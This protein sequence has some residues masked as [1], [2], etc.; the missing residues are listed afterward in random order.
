M[1]TSPKDFILGQLP[2]KTGI[3]WDDSDTIKYYMGQKATAPTQELPMYQQLV[4]M[5]QGG[6]TQGLPYKDQLLQTATS[7]INQQYGNA[8]KDLSDMMSGR[9]LGKSGIGLSAQAN[10][11]GKQSTALNQATSQLN[12]QDIAYRNQAMLSLLGLNT[13]EGTYGLQQ[14]QQQLS[15]LGALLTG[16]NQENQINAEQDAASS[17]L[18]GSA[19]GDIG[20]LLAAPMTG[21]TSLL[22]LLAGGGKSTNGI[23]PQSVIENL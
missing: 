23:V 11:A 6:Y 5:L 13:A 17:K 22:G 9:G 4:G 3:S 10:L 7:A 19:L 14:N 21:G 12:E 15:A 2:P 16:R 20:S 1:A 8:S 18:W